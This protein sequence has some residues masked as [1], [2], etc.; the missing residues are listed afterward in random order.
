MILYCISAS[1]PQ[2][3]EQST[4]LHDLQ[5]LS[6]TSNDFEVVLREGEDLEPVGSECWDWVITFGSCQLKR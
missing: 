6:A 3:H 5:A 4:F 1:D 2:L